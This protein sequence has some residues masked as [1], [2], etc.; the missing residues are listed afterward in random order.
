[1]F[2]FSSD[3]SKVGLKRFRGIG[4]LPEQWETERAGAAGMAWLRTPFTTVRWSPNKIVV[5]VRRPE[6][7]EAICCLEWRKTLEE[8]VVRRRWSGEFSMHIARSGDVMVTSHTKLAALACGGLTKG[9]EPLRP[10]HSLRIK[11]RRPELGQPIRESDFQSGFGMTYAETIEAVRDE[12]YRSVKKLP[13]SFALLLSGGLDSSIIAAIACDLG[14]RIVPFVMSMK[15]S[16]IR[17][18]QQESDLA[19]ARLVTAHLG[20]RCEEIL[21]DANTLAKN[22][23]LAILLA[24]TARGTIIDPCAGLIEVAKRASG[25]G[26]KSVVMGEAADDLFGSFTFAL[27]YARGQ[28]LR[29]FYRKELDVGLPDEIAVLQRIFEAWGISLVDPYWTCGLKRIGYNLPLSYRLDSR[30]LMKRVLRDAFTGMLPEEIILRPKIVTREGS[31]IR[32]ALEKSFGAS[33]QRYRGLFK[34]MFVEGRA[35][36]RN[37]PPL[38][39]SRN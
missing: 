4:A 6:D 25:S 34:Q 2:I 16:I 20:L 21:L 32:Y 33:R 37:L 5:S 7:P 18:S 14:K 10:G 9:I 3:L 39:I 35:W 31:Q 15:R 23:P 12:M 22:V 1:M 28:G 19:C 27:R 36:P 38:K 30:R 26:F 29:S 8:V 11:L 24:E 13:N 17:Q